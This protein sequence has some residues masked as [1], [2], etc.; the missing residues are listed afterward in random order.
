M[1]THRGTAA[2]GLE[3][4]FSELL[5]NSRRKSFS[6][7]LVSKASSIAARS[8]FSFIFV[9]SPIN[10]KSTRRSWVTG[11]QR[12]ASCNLVA[13]AVRRLTIAE[14]TAFVY[15]GSDAPPKENCGLFTIS[16]PTEAHAW[17]TIRF[18]K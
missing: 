13:L 8:R 12:L 3:S 7:S 15:S 18:P 10:T 16:K 5:P 9:V 2:N 1:A 6:S 14:A 4:T 17:L 11:C